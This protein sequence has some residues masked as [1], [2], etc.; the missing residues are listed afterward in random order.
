M[1]ERSKAVGFGQAVK[2]FV[3][4]TFDYKGRSTRA[5]FWWVELAVFILSMILAIIVSVGISPIDFATTNKTVDF[6]TEWPFLVWCAIL[7]LPSFSLQIRRFRDAGVSPWLAVFITVF[8]WLFAGITYALPGQVLNLWWLSLISSLL[9][10]VSFIVTLLPSHDAPKVAASASG[11]VTIGRAFKL[12][13]T[14]FFDFRGRSSRSAYW[15]AF[16]WNTLIRVIGGVLVFIV[17][18]TFF[19]FSLMKQSST[20]STASSAI[21]SVGTPSILIVGFIIFLFSV[22]DLAT[23]IP[24]LMITI[25]RYRDAGISPWWFAVILVSV[26]VMAG[27]F[28][29]NIGNDWQVVKAVVLLAILVIHFIILIRPTKQ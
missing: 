1:E 25:R 26:I 15:W 29:G 28:G 27:L 12:F 19:G 20:G 16:F 10:L 17:A 13:W 23:L 5:A 21:S 4:R 9:S 7:I 6:M 14:H 2:E 8:G 11:P 24:S 22:Y 3:T 18:M